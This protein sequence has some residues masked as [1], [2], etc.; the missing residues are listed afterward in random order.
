MANSASVTSTDPFANTLLEGVDPRSVV[1]GIIFSVIV[2]V[3]FHLGKRLL[4]VGTKTASL[5]SSNGKKAS[6]KASDEEDTDAL[7]TDIAVVD[8]TDIGKSDKPAKKKASKTRTPV[9]AVI[10]SVYPPYAGLYNLGNTCYMNVVLQALFF[11]PVFRRAVAAHRIGTPI[12]Y[13][14]DGNVKDTVPNK[15]AMFLL[16]FQDCMCRLNQVGHGIQTA[17]TPS[18]PTSDPLS[19]TASDPL[20]LKTSASASKKSSKSPPQTLSAIEQYVLS[21]PLAV[22]PRLLA[23]VLGIDPSYPHDISEFRSGVL[24]PALV[25]AYGPG[26]DI[27][28]LFNTLFQGNFIQA[29]QCKRIDLSSTVNELF[30]EMNIQVKSFTCLEDAFAGFLDK[31]DLVG[32]NRYNAAGHGKQDAW[33]QYFIQKA[34]VILTFHL[35][36]AGFNFLS[37]R[38]TK[39][40]SPFSFPLEINLKDYRDLYSDAPKK[41][42][43]D[44]SLIYDLFVVITNKLKVGK[45]VTLSHYITYMR[46]PSNDD[47]LWLCLNDAAA[48]Y[49]P[50]NVA[51]DKN[52]D[53]AKNDGESAVSLQYIRRSEIGRVFHPDLE[54]SD[55][56]DQSVLVGPPRFT[57]SDSYTLE[58]TKYAQMSELRKQKAKPAKKTKVSGKR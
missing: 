5:P 8:E 46:D 54:S 53:D 39:V 21:N 1:N 55:E 47:G 22:S 48:S 9:S 2:L 11:I 31:S 28:R 3:V 6:G 16:A 56:P 40:V 30:Y 34:P 57:P 43:D 50:Q 35:R 7:D 42:A 23:Y 4:S 17:Q 37:G 41:S 44:G 29:V 10:P 49:V 15:R 45:R 36:K 38:S 58:R 32:E 12:D 26:S 19:L 27:V 18:L 24:I 52:F 51:V 14:A 33:S 25:D 20:S 13:D